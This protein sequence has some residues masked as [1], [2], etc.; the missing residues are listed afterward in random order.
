VGKSLEDSSVSAPLFVHA[1]P[2]NKNNSGLKFL[3]W[4][5]SPIPELGVVPIH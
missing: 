3:R 5:G 2:L 4:M 1:F